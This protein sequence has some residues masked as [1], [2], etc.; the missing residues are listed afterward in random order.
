MADE[1]GEEK[2]KKKVTKRNSA[3]NA[4]MKL[5]GLMGVTSAESVEVVV[6]KS[7]AARALGSLTGGVTPGIAE[8]LAA[9]KVNDVYLMSQ[10]LDQH[11]PRGLRVD[12]RDPMNRSALH[13]AATAG[14]LVAI[15]F[16]LSRGAE[17]SPK[18]SWDATP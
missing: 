4:L 6:E 18:D 5:G 8:F 11:G 16:L 15:K 13:E 17:P 3:T 12:S 14:H 9:A 1:G 10:L 7:D 2:K